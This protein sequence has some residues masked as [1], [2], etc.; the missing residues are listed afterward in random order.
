MNNRYFNKMAKSMVKYS[1]RPTDWLVG[2]EPWFERE[3]EAMTF[4][5]SF[6]PFPPETLKRTNLELNFL[7]IGAETIV[8]L[9]FCLK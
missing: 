9:S 1:Q 7:L 2:Y 6:S 5:F 4:L 8:C 3:R